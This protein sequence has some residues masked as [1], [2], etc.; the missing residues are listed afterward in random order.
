MNYTSDKENNK[1]LKEVG[2]VLKIIRL[3]EGLSQTE[4][5]LESNLNRSLLQRAEMG[6]NI[7]LKSLLKI[8]GAYNYDIPLFLSLF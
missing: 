3:N 1:E 7:T 2:R 4:L 5:S 6:E 8:L